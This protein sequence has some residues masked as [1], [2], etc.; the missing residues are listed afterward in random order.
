[1]R[2]RSRTLR[3]GGSSMPNARRRL[4][5]PAMLIALAALFVSLSGVSYAAL[6][7]DSV[8]SKHIKNGAVKS[9]DIANNGVKG[10]DVDEA[11]LG[12]VPQAENAAQLG[13][14]AAAELIRKADVMWVEFEHDGTIVNASHPG[15]TAANQQP[16]G[17]V[18]AFFPRDVSECFTL[19]QTE[20]SEGSDDAPTVSWA[21]P[22]AGQPNGMDVA[23]EYYEGTTTEADSYRLLVICP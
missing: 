13:G 7:K 23:T 19:S 1:M 5:S 21:Y 16:Y 8:K 14:I 2:G 20:D 10:A 22:T 6:A 9:A 17:V 15:I 18:R 12:V 4:P 3:N 11:S